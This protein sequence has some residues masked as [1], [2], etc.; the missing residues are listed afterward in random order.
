MALIND[1]G[2]IIA[3]LF[4]LL[5]VFM[6]TAKT[7]RKLPNYLFASFLLISLVDLSGFFLNTPDHKVVKAF[8]ISSILLQM[9]LYYLYVNAACYY[10]FT[11]KK[12]HILHG[13]PF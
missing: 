3:F 6:I 4:L 13:I 8:K 10:N 2:K 1:L 11:L 12:H 5:S 9:P 7:K